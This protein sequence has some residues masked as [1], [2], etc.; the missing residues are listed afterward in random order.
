MTPTDMKI[1][2]ETL[3][4]NASLY[5]LFKEPTG[6]GVS[7]VELANLWNEAEEQTAKALALLNAIMRVVN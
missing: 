2:Q 4:L 7:A 1:I 3:Q 5:E 6:R